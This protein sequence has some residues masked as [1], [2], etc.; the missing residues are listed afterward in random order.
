MKRSM[1]EAFENYRN[2][3]K[4]EAGKLKNYLMGRIIPGT[5]VYYAPK[6]VPIIGAVPCLS[7]KQRAHRKGRN[8]MA[9]ESRRRNRR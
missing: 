9:A 3:I 7:R 6:K 1:G 2:R 5:E 4:E 8:K